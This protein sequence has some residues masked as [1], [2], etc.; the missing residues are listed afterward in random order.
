MWE[1]HSLFLGSM[2]R[3]DL[4]S[5]IFG[6]G[7]YLDRDR[8]MNEKDIVPTAMI[9]YSFCRVNLDFYHERDMLYSSKLEEN[10]LWA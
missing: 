5:Y 10:G 7:R 1:I 6:T 2:E 4:R 3:H 9:A 8:D